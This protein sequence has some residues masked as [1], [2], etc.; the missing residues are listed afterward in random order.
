MAIRDRGKKKW[1][2][3]FFMPE[4]VKAQNELWRDAQRQLKPIMDEYEKE[5][6]DQRISYAMEYHLPVLLTIW[7][8]GFMEVITGKVH[9]VDP[10]THQ[11]RIETK[12]GEFERVTFD[13]VVGVNVD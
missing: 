11:L 12:P 7:S 10:I 8:D 3:A 4:Q 9:Y 1:Q 13:S 6:F 2:G 5:E